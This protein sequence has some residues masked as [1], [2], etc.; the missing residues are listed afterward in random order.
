MSSRIVT[1]TQLKNHLGEY[2][3]AAI[4]HPVFVQKSGREVV[5]LVSRDYY[6]HLQT[7]ED[8]LWALRALLAE[9]RG[10]LG[11]EDT[12]RVLKEELLPEDESAC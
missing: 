4:A 9:Q 1:A 6:A 3:E 7:L 8:E 10:Y 11:V 2:L 12:A 5:V